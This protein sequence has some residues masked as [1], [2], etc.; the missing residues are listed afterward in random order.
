MNKRPLIGVLGLAR[1]GRAATQLAL[2]H[3]FRVYASDASDSPALQQVARE[4]Q[5]KGADVQLGGHALERLAAC[6]LIVVSPGIPPS[7]PVLRAE[8]MRSVR[9][10]SELELAFQYLGSPV[11]AVTGTNGKSTTTAM[12]SHLLRRGGLDAPAA[13]NIGTAL[14][15]I[16]LRA[17]PPDWVVVEASSFQLADIERFTA[18]IGVVTNLAP[19][20][21]DRYDSVAT[22]YADKAKLFK[23]ASSASV[24]VLNGD[25]AAVLALPG[26]VPGRRFYFRISGELGR[27]EVGG[28]ISGR[29][30]LVLRLGTA[31]SP[32]LHIS[33]L[34]LLGQ[35]NWANA[36]AA[37]I[38]A[39]AAEVPIDVI[40]DGL[41]SFRGL[42]HRLE[43]VRELDGVLWINDSKATN[44]ASTRVA[45]QS[46]TRP[47]VLLLGGRHKGEPYT[48]LLTELRNH[49][50][51]VI[52]YGEAAPLVVQDLAAHVAVELVAGGFDD[53]VERAA[54]VAS[55]GDAVL[56][57]PACASFD[58]FDNYE[59]RG[60]RF[61]KRVAQLAQVVNG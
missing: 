19:D 6:A 13:G 43:V 44:I 41:T 57:S 10:I 48:N 5:A 3:G 59:Q 50:R 51:A 14:S 15:E 8:A 34:P 4:L 35:H 31:E 20:H 9:R 55:P 52:A 25:D 53:A 30:H 24:W 28:F 40:Q 49:V 7:A 17:E 36:L 61:K 16:A 38:T 23:N 39:A 27:G 47:T 11:I 29:G 60:E 58:Q 2:A 26:N 33:D 42:P 54:S 46:M 1:S 21:L 32:L 56:L 22:Y 45:L 37:A 12:I 18:R